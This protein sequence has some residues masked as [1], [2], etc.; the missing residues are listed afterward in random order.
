MKPEIFAASELFS[1]EP[2]ILS[3][4]G[5]RLLAE[6]DSWF[7]IGTLNVFQSSNILHGLDFARSTAVVTC[8]Y[9]GDTLQHMVDNLSDPYFDRLLCK[10]NFASY[11]EA[12]L[13][14]G[15][16]NDLIDAA[17]VP[18]VDH[19]GKAVPQDRRLLLTP[20]EA[21]QN[22]REFRARTLHQRGR[23]GP[24]PTVCRA[25]FAELVSGRER[26]PA[27]PH[28]QSSRGRP[29]FVH[30]YCR[31]CR[32]LR[33]RRWGG[34][35]AGCIRRWS[36]TAFRLPTGRPWGGLLFERLRQLLLGLDCDSGQATALPHVHVFDSAGLGTIR[37]ALPG[38]TRQSGDW[39]NKEIHL[40]PGGYRKL[41]SAFGKLHGKV[42]EAIPDAS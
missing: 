15:G 7:T 28:G 29:M 40:T 32:A 13:I 5:R 9:P 39:V 10:R 16:G 37:P 21:A 31:A 34:P 26:R 33:G 22:L 8:A 38:S 2:P 12:L 6:G 3:I 23:L 11:W 27:V 30:T 20:Q 42:F 24:W 17:Q 1:A 36:P 35:R 18:A 41:G 4:Y 19:K 14:S 25:N